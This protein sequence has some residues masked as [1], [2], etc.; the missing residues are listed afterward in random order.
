MINYSRLAI[1]SIL[2]AALIIVVL[3][4]YDKVVNIIK[5]VGL[6]DTDHYLAANEEE[7]D[8]KKKSGQNASQLLFEKQT[9][10]KRLFNCG[11]HPPIKNPLQVGH[12]LYEGRKYHR[13]SQKQPL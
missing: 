6:G 1:S 8:G 3:M 12:A 13:L 4:L 10:K 9:Y 2:S 7:N 5:I 11:P